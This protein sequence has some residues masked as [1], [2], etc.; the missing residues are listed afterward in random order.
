MKDGRGSIFLQDLKKIL[1]EAKAARNAGKGP[2]ITRP[3]V[4]YYDT[5]DESYTDGNIAKL[6]VDF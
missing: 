5:A 4:D 2:E 6:A 1:A 3:A